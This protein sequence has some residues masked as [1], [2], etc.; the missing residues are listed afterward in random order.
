MNYG[1]EYRAIIAAQMRSAY[2]FA[3]NGAADELKVPAPSTNRDT[4]ALINQSAQ[5]VVDKQFG[6]LLFAIK[7]EVL[8]E[9][10]KNTL[11]EISLGLSDILGAI[12]DAFNSFFDSKLSLT[13][14]IVIAQGVNRGRQDVFEAYRDRISVY[15]Y[16]AILDEHT[17]P[18]RKTSMAR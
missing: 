14:A 5:A 11:S 2:D 18:I 7:S 3:K 17:C 10:R 8:K 6:D 9:L 4:T 12:G 1:N 15:Q 16:S 13:G